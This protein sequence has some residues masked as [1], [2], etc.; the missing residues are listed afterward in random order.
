[1]K[2]SWMFSKVAYISFFIYKKNDGKAL[3]E[4]KKI[5]RLGAECKMR[6]NFLVSKRTRYFTTFF[7]DGMVRTARLVG[8][9]AD[10]RFTS[11]VARA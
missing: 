4:F 7:V 8:E 1:M 6:R 10:C 2:Q 11:R 3:I 9:K 5:H